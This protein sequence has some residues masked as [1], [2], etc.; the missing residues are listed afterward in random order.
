[1][2]GASRAVA[3][4]F[5]LALSA[6]VAASVMPAA[7]QAPAPPFFKDR[8]ITLMIGFGPGGGNDVWARLVA[9]HIG[10]HIPGRP[11]IVPQNVP[12][13]GGLALANQIYNVSPKDGTV[14]GNISRGI[15]MEPLLGGQGAQ[16][17]PLRIGWIGSPDRDTAICVARADS[18]I[19]SLADLAH[20]ELVMGA[21]GSGTDSAVYPEFLGV[22]LGLKLKTVKGYKGSNEMHLAMERGEVQGLCGSHDSV[23]TGSGRARAGKLVI[24]FQGRLDPDPRLPGV[25][26]WGDIARSEEQRQVLQ[27]FLTRSALGRPFLAPPGLPAERLA[28]LRTAFTATMA[29]TG[30]IA[31][32]A[33]HNFTVEPLTGAELAATLARAYAMPPEIV[34]RTRE[35]L[36]RTGAR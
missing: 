8:T 34:Q 7:A 31:E 28:V 23:M 2:P 3:A 30:F 24:L 12:G 14:L 4:A 16:F 9:R 29:D 22:L 19:G 1:M 5:A 21:T 13:A 32:A 11:T 15:P 33:R 27:L 17:D 36:G 6:H 25:A 18:G 35:V 26:Y 10:R 20:K